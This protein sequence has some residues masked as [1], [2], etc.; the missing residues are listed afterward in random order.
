[1]VDQIE[2][3]NVILLN[4]IDMVTEEQKREVK[5]AILQFNKKAEIIETIK[6]EVDLKKVL[7]TKKFNFEEAEDNSKW[8]EQDR[9]DITPETEEY[10][11]SSFL[12]KRDRPF[13]PERFF[14]LVDDNFTGWDKHQAGVFK[15]VFRAKGFL[16]LTAGESDFFDDWCKTRVVNHFCVG[17]PW[18]LSLD[19][20]THK[21]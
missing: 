20:H 4:K 8:L 13:F 7:N 3:S 10:G 9:Y 17:G 18:E 14:T 21:P 2:F 5:N 12:Y 19:D 16:W 6:S 15:H 11:I 1:M